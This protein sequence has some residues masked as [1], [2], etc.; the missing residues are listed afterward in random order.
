MPKKPPNDMTA[1][2]T[3]PLIFSIIKRSML[4]ILLPLGS[5][6]VVPSTRSL[7]MSGFPVICVAAWVTMSV[8]PSLPLPG[9]T[10]EWAIGARL[11]EISEKR[12]FDVL[13]IR[14]GRHDGE[15]HGASVR[16]PFA[17]Q[18][19]SAPLLHTQGLKS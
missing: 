12:A 7:S 10:P 15:Y 4:P 16:P 3:R 1:Y 9:I 11:R 18:R 2:A 19:G 6:T 13:N 8:P 17:L 14:T 5:Y